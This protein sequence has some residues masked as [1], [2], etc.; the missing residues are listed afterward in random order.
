MGYTRRQF[1]KKAFEAVGLASYVFDLDTDELEAAGQSLDAMIA[2]WNGRGIRLGYPIP[3]NPEDGDLDEQTKV[4]DW[5]N[6]AISLNLGI[7]LADGIGKQHSPSLLARAKAALNGVMARAAMPSEMQP[8]SLPAG[9][10]HKS[11]EAPF[12][13]EPP[14]SLDA[15]PDSILTFE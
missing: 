13:P 11:T 7:I 15:G 14:S 9:A 3:L 10:G 5:A 1:V 8:S 12:L 4:P 2:E 6:S